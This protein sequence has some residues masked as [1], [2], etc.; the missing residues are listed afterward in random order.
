M[1]IEENLSV[2]LIMFSKKNK[3]EIVKELTFV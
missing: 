3:S 2:P 1:T